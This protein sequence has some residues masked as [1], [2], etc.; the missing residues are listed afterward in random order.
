M[1]KIIIL[2]GL[3]LFGCPTVK[4]DCNFNEHNQVLAQASKIKK[5]Q[6]D[7]ADFKATSENQKVLK[8]KQGETLAHLLKPYGLNAVDILDISNKLNPYISVNKMNVGQ[9][10]NLIMNGNNIKRIIIPIAFNQEITL[11]KIKNIWQAQKSNLETETQYKLVAGRIEGS[12]YQSALE[13]HAPLSVINRFMLAYSHNVDFQRSIRKG[14]SF[15]LIYTEK[16][17]K[18]DSEI[19]QVDKLK[20]A[21]LTLSN[22]TTRLYR[23]ESIDK[24][25]YFYDNEGKLANSFLLKTPLEGARLSSHFG[26]RKHPVLGYTRIHKGIDFGAPKGTPI[27]AAG[28]G[29]IEKS[30]WGGSFGNLIRIKHKNGYQSLYAHLNGFA[31]GIKKGVKVK[32]GQIIGYLGNTGLSQARHLHYEIHK[33]GRAIDPLKLKQASSIK[34]KGKQLIAFEKYKKEIDGYLI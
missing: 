33:N 34:L 21:E 6:I 5:N 22:K 12:F 10:I 25:A 15:R 2:S 16:F 29:I 17:L 26:K 11:N 13:T 14:D 28:N 20:Y 8:L 24:G 31:K 4:K 18:N 1:K 23:F 32:Q 19:K 3:F 30:G 27:L 9:S 7:F